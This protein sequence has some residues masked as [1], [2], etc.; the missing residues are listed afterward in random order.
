MA[1]QPEVPYRIR[2]EGE[3]HVIELQGDFTENPD[4]ELMH[5]DLADLVDRLVEP[6][7]V[8]D[9][10]KVN[11]VSSRVFG[12]MLGLYRRVAQKQG[13]FVI[14]GLNMHLAEMFSLM[15]L[16][17]VFKI[18]GDVGEAM[19]EATERS[20]DVSDEATKGRQDKK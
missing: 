2:V 3:V 13:R 16:N 12:L 18:V 1:Q 19:K 7:L 6:R 8:V 14:C 10:A 4:L 15:R 9:F 5:C 11:Y 20:P 17:M